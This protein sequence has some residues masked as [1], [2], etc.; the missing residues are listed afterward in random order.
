MKRNKLY[1]L[2]L[3]SLLLCGCNNNSTNNNSSIDNNDDTSQGDKSDS[4]D[5]G[6]TSGDTTDDDDGGD[7]PIEVVEPKINNVI[8]TN[9]IS[10]FYVGETSNDLSAE[11]FG[12]DGTNEKYNRYVTFSEY[13]SSIIEIES[14]QNHP[15]V[16]AL[17]AGT[18]SVKA[19]SNG[20]VNKYDVTTITVLD[21]IVESISLS[22]KD[23]V[24]IEKIKALR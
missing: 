22:L 24:N 2:A 21:P 1:L 19:I 18:T 5:G 10:D 8:I 4:T 6:G 14:K 7:T 15:Q 23:S 13:D 16:K 11:V 9:N 20:D 12:I 3:I 17:K